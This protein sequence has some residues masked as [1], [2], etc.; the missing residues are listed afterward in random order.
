MGSF[1]PIYGILFILNILIKL[2][3]GQLGALTETPV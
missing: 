2:F 3:T 1:F